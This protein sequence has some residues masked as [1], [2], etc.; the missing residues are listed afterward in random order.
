[1]ISMFKSLW[2]F[3][4][5]ILSSI[6]TDFR[7]RFARSKLGAI[8]IVLN[9]LAQVLM[10]ALVLSAVLSSKLP[11][12]SSRFAYAI[13]LLAGM[14]CWSLFTELLMKTSTLFI[15]NSNLIKK[16][17]FPKLALPTILVGVSLINNIILFLTMIFVFGLLGHKITHE[18]L[19][20]IPLML[21]TVAI[22]LG[23][24]LILGVINVFI[25]DI[26]QIIPI[27]LQFAFWFTP[28]V[29]PVEVIP[30]KYTYLLNFNPFYGIISSYQNVLVLGKSPD[31]YNLSIAV[32][33]SAATLLLGLF[34]FKR[35]S[36][37]IVDAI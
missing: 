34:L 23:A 29:Y 20:I 1:M 9:P 8:W 13:Y 28:I 10:Y 7:T 24:G 21:I 12:V 19:W 36:S 33:V 35:A 25:R 26:G 16:I 14:L 3:R 2:R 4:F 5:F 27:L 18:V 37:E 31:I 30:E 15:D 11:G 22:G 17:V 6:K 32:I